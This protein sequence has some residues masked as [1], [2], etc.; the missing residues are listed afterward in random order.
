MLTKQIDFNNFSLVL[1]GGGAL[2]ISA[3]GVLSDMEKYNI[4]PKEIIGTSMGSIIGACLAIG[5]KEKQIY[6]LFCDFSKISNWIKF[7]MRGNSIITNDKIKN[8]FDQV[9]QNKRICDVLIPLKLVATD[10]KTGNIK[11]FSSV[12]DKV[13]LKDA[14][15]ASMAIP[16]IFE[17]QHIDNQVYV[18]GFLCANLAINETSLEDILAIDVLGANSFSKDLPNNMLKTKN[19]FDM[20]DKSLRILIYNQTK[21]AITHCDKKIFLIEPCTKNFKSFHF[22]KYQELKKLGIGIFTKPIRA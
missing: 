4:N 5:L 22:H 11:V 14:V 2:G 18:D 3:L 6:D 17:E 20:F 19:I 9:F 21:V 10:I 1:S 13:L 16:G 15:M 7:S 8:I 12:D